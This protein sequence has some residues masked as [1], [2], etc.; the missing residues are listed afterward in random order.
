MN[1]NTTNLYGNDGRQMRYTD[2]ALKFFTDC[3]S[4]AAFHAAGKCHTLGHC[5]LC[6][7]LRKDINTDSRTFVASDANVQCVLSAVFDFP[8]CRKCLAFFFFFC[9][10]YYY[11]LN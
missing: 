5:Y 3:Y 8:I 9:L 7:G 2:H 11:K 6:A 4:L 10:R 1:N